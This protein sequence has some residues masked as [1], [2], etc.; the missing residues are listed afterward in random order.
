MKKFLFAALCGSVLLSSCQ[1]EPMIDISYEKAL[2]D[3]RWVLADVKNNPNT[4][5]ETN[6]WTSTFGSI[7]PCI[8]DNKWTFTSRTNLVVDEGWTKCT[9][10][11]PQTLE[12][13][14]DVSDEKTMKIFSDRT[15]PDNTIIIKGD[16]KMVDINT[17]SIDERKPN[18]ADTTKIISNIYTYKKEI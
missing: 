16:F 6:V 4:K 11:A 1:P 15:N 7:P 12:L 17:F 18:P 9:G 13:F 5:V 8:K 10:S 14:Y 2:M 3:K